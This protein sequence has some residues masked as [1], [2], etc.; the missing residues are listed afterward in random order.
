M[1]FLVISDTHIGTAKMEYQQQKGYPEKISELVNAL[2]KWIIEQKDIDFVLHAGD[3]VDEATVENIKLA[4]QIFKISVPVYLCLGN[5]DLNDKNALQNW[6]THAPDFFINQSPDYL[7]QRGNADVQV[8][9]SHWDEIPFFWGSVQ[10]PHFISPALTCNTKILCTHSPVY[11][12]LREQTGFSEEHH[13]GGESFQKELLKLIEKSS[14]ECVISGHTHMN[15]RVLN[16]GVDFVTA[17]SF[18]EVPFEAKLFNLSDSELEMGTISFLNY[19][20]FSSEYNFNKT[21]VQGRPIDRS[22]RKPLQKME[23]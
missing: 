5:H 4:K 21:F 19:V 1:K 6:M 8:I 17:S 20:D 12:V 16:D 11:G 14:V 3:M 10:N 9:T 22:F 18:S 15:S 2:D 23:I 7:I 13:S